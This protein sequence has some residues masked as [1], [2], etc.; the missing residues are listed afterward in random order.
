MADLP[1]SISPGLEL[2]KCTW[3]GIWGFVYA[4]KAFYQLKYILSLSCINPQSSWGGTQEVWLPIPGLQGGKYG[5]S[6]PLES[7]FMGE[8]RG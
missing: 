5:P 4:R 6:L 2:W 1:S 3:D 7:I 8:K